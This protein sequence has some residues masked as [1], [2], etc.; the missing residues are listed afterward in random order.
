MNGRTREGFYALWTLAI[1]I[2][3]VVCVVVLAYVSIADGPDVVEAPPVVLDGD[4]QSQ[5]QQDGSQPLSED[6]QQVPAEGDASQVPPA[7]D[8][9]ADG[10]AASTDASQSQQPLPVVLGETADMGMDYQGRIVFLGDSTTYGLYY[11]GALPHSQVW[12]PASG[13]LSLFNWAVETVEYYPPGDSVNAQTMSIVDCVTARQPEY[14]V[15]TLGVNGITILDEEG[16]KGYYTGLVQAIAQASPNTKIICNSIFPVIDGKAP[17][18]I[19]NDLIITANGWILDVAAETG[20]RYLNSH[21]YIMDETGGLPAAY[22]GGDGLHMNTDGYN[23][24]MQ[25]VRT[26]AW[27]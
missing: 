8:Q 15:I 21:D 20:A 6:G 12:T 18:D 16:F 27:Q 11:Y 24:V 22:D 14:L 17:S 19:T 26:H 7:G 4:G 10:G 9:T 13:T 23:A 3:L 2:C 5:L 1:L 25:C